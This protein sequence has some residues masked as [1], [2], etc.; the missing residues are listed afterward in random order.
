VSVS[1]AIRHLAITGVAVVLSACNGTQQSPAGSTGAIPQSPQQTRSIAKLVTKSGSFLNAPAAHP[2]LARAWMTPDKSKKKGALLYV[3]NYSA[4]EVLVYSYPA[5]KLVGTLTSDLVAP[6]GICTD[7]KGNVWIGNN[8]GGSLV[9]YAH[10]ATTPTMTLSDP[11][12][13]PGGCSVDPTTG[14]LAVANLLTNSYS[15]DPG[16]VAIY[17]DAKGTPTTYSDPAMY[18]VYFVGYDDSG[19]LYVTGVSPSATFQFAELP[20]GGSS[21]INITLT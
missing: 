8:Q 17:T 20:K 11:Y 9:A 10:G 3:S 14:N 18:Y 12:A 6:D 4:D 21:L 13:Y 19:N 15:Y 7:K 2:S 1:P 5:L 16:D